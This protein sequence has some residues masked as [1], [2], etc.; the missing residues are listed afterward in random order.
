[1]K[2]F[3]GRK[4]YASSRFRK[5]MV[6]ATPVTT[7][8]IQKNTRSTGIIKYIPITTYEEPLSLQT[9]ICARERGFCNGANPDTA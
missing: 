7:P 5:K 2:Y 1:M 9:G 6:E 3:A 4:I 8:T